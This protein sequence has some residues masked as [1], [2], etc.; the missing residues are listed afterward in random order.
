MAVPPPGLKPQGGLPGRGPGGRGTVRPWAAY[1]ASRAVPRRCASATVY[2]ERRAARASAWRCASPGPAA[3]K[4]VWRTGLVPR[5][6]TVP[7]G[8]AEAEPWPPGLGGDSGVPPPKPAAS[9]LTLCWFLLG[10]KVGASSGGAMPSRCGGSGAE[11]RDGEGE[12]STAPGAGAGLGS[13][14]APPKR[15]TSAAVGGAERGE[16]VELTGWWRE[17]WRLLS[18]LRGTWPPVWRWRGDAAL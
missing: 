15:G 18:R 12:T 10:S 9:C 11:S 5:G 3:L 4:P 2:L 16:L 6:A 14:V 13:S 7:A 1:S 17:L 8:P